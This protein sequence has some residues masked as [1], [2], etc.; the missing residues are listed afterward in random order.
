M[1]QKLV[2]YFS[3]NKEIAQFAELLADAMDADLFDADLLMEKCGDTALAGS[4]MCQ[5]CEVSNDRNSR[6]LIKQFRDRMETYDLVYIGFPA[7]KSEVSQS[8]L[9]M[10]CDVFSN[11]IIVPFCLT[12]NQNA[13]Q[14]EEFVR[15]YYTGATVLQ[16]AI[17]SADMSLEELSDWG[18]MMEMIAENTASYK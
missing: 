1:Y 9:S 12:E 14:I 3:A 11:K 2:V 15:Q 18:K 5:D 7:R 8:I 16:A 10:K 17:L 4:L 13:K 6:D